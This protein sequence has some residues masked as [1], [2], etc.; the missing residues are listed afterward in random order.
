MSPVR[1]HT[2]PT[3]ATEATVTDAPRLTRIPTPAPRRGPSLSPPA[4]VI[5]INSSHSSRVASPR[6]TGPIPQLP[7]RPPVSRSNTTPS[8]PVTAAT[9][10]PAVVPLDRL[11]DDDIDVHEAGAASTSDV[12]AAMEVDALLSTTRGASSEL[13]GLTEA[14]GS[15]KL[16]TT[17]PSDGGDVIASR[18][19]S[20][21]R[22]Q[23][24]QPSTASSDDF[25][26]S[27]DYRSK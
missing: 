17:S 3:A 20:P 22:P 6:P 7:F 24:R 19:T 4:S 23:P 27:D 25:Y 9:A 15:Q 1:R 13:D 10:G 21:H 16:K 12:D 26:A 2:M 14:L 5:S 11:F 8:I 18:E